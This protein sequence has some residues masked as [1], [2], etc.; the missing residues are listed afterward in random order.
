MRAGWPVTRH[1]GGWQ[2]RRP[3]PRTAV[4]DG[5]TDDGLGVAGTLCSGQ[6]WEGVLRVLR[7]LREGCWMVWMEQDGY[8]M[9]EEGYR[10]VTWW[11]WRGTGGGSLDGSRPLS[12]AI[13]RTPNVCT[14]RSRLDRRKGLWR[15]PCKIANVRICLSVCL[16]VFLHG[17]ARVFEFV[18]WCVVFVY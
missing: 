7:G 3:T 17:I 10:M 15:Y 13:V 9:E 5:A 6:N 12:P 1:R 11:C 4:R 2:P 18:C 16:C 14:S 8:R